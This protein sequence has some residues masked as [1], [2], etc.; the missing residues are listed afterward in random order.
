M[1]VLNFTPF[2]EW[3]PRAVK[4]AMRD[5]SDVSLTMLQADDVGD[6]ETQREINEALDNIM[7]LRKPKSNSGGSAPTNR[8]KAKHKLD[9]FVD[10]VVTSGRFSQDPEAVKEIERLARLNHFDYARERLPATKQLGVTAK[11]LDTVVKAYRKR[12]RAEENA[13]DEQGAAGDGGDSGGIDEESKHV[14]IKEWNRQYAVVTHGSTTAVVRL[15]TEVPVFMKE[16][17]FKF[18]LRNQYYMDY[19]D[20]GVLV[21]MPKAPKWLA[22]TQRAQF[23]HP[24]V[25]FVPGRDPLHIKGRSF[26]LRG[27]W[28]VEP[29][30]G[31]WP[32]LRDHIEYV[33]CG[34]NAIAAAYLV[35]W[36][37]YGVQNPLKRPEV[38]PVLRGK[39]GVGKGILWRTYGK[40]YGRHFKHILRSEQLMGRFNAIVGDAQFIFL[41]EALFAGSPQDNAIFKGMVTEETLQLER[42]FIDPVTIKNYARIALA[43]NADWAV[44]VDIG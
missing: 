20:N 31:K 44:M 26:N 13:D 2:R 3:G 15:D 36:M 41:D 42:K 4:M 14:W 37:A 10:N 43:T 11:V 39:P 17:S 6:E 25:E 38:V 9:E 19:D 22:S 7:P 8:K 27:G 1:P 5:T 33:V 28:G 21:P 40:L 12:L 24:G 35:K 16:D 32:L 30:S 34:G 18:M 23:I 29:K